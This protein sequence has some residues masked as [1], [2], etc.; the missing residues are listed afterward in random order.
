MGQNTR[1]LVAALIASWVCLPASADLVPAIEPVVPAGEEGL[2]PFVPISE[3]L[4]EAL[5]SDGFLEPVLKPVQK[6]IP[7][8]CQLAAKR[9]LEDG[10]IEYVAGPGQVFEAAAGERRLPG[11]LR[12]PGAARFSIPPASAAEGT[13]LLV[14]DEMEMG[15]SALAVEEDVCVECAAAD[16]D[17]GELPMEK[18]EV[19]GDE[20]EVAEDEFEV[21]GDEFVAPPLAGAALPVGFPALSVG[22]GTGRFVPILPVVTFGGGGGGGGGTPGGETPR[23][24]GGGGPGVTPPPPPAPIPL[25][26]AGAMALLGLGALGAARRARRRA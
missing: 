9:A 10:S 15:G 21:L 16:F 26:P 11:G 20:F 14:Q 22:G 6:P 17:A 3:E 13:L 5:K 7:V 18:W 1:L 2:E 8:W 12:L 24:P 19:L 25:P 4:A 23:T